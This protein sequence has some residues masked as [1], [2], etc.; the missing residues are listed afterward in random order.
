MMTEKAA[1]NMIE[2]AHIFAGLG[3]KAVAAL[4]GAAKA[5]TAVPGEIIV[6]E[7]T[8]GREMYLIGRGRVEVVKGVGSSRETKLAILGPGE[9]FGEM[10]ILE[11]M[12]RSASIRCVEAC[13]LYSV[14]S[15]D[16]L[17]LFQQWPDQYAILM[18]NMARHLSRRLRTMDEVFAA[19]AF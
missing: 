11:C 16:L 8:Q 12:A 14:K 10:S 9:S 15:E 4:A 13:A 3:D 2:S 5:S 19:K 18:V 6:R 7:G 1:K 17:R